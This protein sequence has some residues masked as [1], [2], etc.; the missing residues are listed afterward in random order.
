MVLCDWSAQKYL[1]NKK[2]LTTVQQLFIKC[3]QGGVINKLF[4]EYSTFQNIPAIMCSPK[5]KLLSM[6]L[7]A[8]CITAPSQ[9]SR[10]KGVRA[11]LASFYD[12]AADFKCLDGSNLIPFIQVN[13]DYCDC[14]VRNNQTN[15]TEVA[16]VPFPPPCK[17]E[18]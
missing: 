13:D 10:P 2:S 16:V 4:F 15:D 18:I 11:E 14:E 6:G 1:P 5:P 12:P 3:R 8:L 17:V 7:I 9:A